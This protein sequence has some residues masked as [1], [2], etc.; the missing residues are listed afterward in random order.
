MLADPSAISADDP[1]APLARHLLTVRDAMLAHPELVGG[2][3]DRLDTSLMKAIPGRLVAK[4]GMEALRGVGILPG[5]RGAGSAAS[6]LALKIE[7][8]D[9]YERATWAASV[10][11][12][13]QV[14]VLE[15]QALRSLAR[16]HRP[17]SLDPHGRLAAEAVPVVRA[18]TGGRAHRLT[19]EAGRVPSPARRRSMTFQGDPYR[20][21]GVAPGASL[22]E[23]QLRVPPAGEEVPPGRGRRAC[24][25]AV[26]RDPGGV[27]ACW[28]TA[29]GRPA[30]ARDRARPAAASRDPW[31][32]DPGR[33][34]ASRDAWRARRSGSGGT[35]GHRASGGGAA[36][37]PAS[38]RGDRRRDRR[39]RRR[40]PARGS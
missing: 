21:L 8:G 15:G 24:P 28:S 13:R 6:G 11:A 33:A 37:R 40:G 23:I 26:P 12:L 34:R 30:A 18:R 7:D 32:A 4:S 1:R 27:R 10:E 19:R 22:N 2:T 29:E 38:R 36:G 31:R 39:R 25:A 9:G 17:P 16:Y 35:A 5:A 3:R 14:G 20:T